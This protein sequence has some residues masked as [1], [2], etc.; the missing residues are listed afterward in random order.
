M[1]FCPNKA[2]KDWVYSVEKLG[3]ERTL[4]MY[5]ALGQNI[6]T[7]E[8]VDSIKLEVT[9]IV[10][11]KKGFL[12]SPQQVLSL[13][14][15]TKSV[16]EAES[17]L[18]GYKRVI[19]SKRW[20][21]KIWVKSNIDTGYQQDYV[22][23]AK[24]LEDKVN[25]IYPNLIVVDYKPAASWKHQRAIH[26]VWVNKIEWEKYFG[27]NKDKYFTQGVLFKGG[28]EKSIND[29]RAKEIEDVK[30]FLSTIRNETDAYEV[31]N[32][33]LD[34]Y[35]GI[36][37]S[38]LELIGWI[39]EVRHLNPNISF[40]IAE[41]LEDL[42]EK[43]PDQD[44]G[45]ES[46]A[47]YIQEN[48]TIVL[49]RPLITN[50]LYSDNNTVIASVIHE[51]LHSFTVAPFYKT[52][53]ELTEAEKEFVDNIT[54]LYNESKKRSKYKDE[55]AYTSVKEFIADGLAET[56]IIAELK[57]MK[58]P[59]DNLT[60]WEKI[61]HFILKLFGKSPFTESH[62]YKLLSTINDYVYR[63]DYRQPASGS[64]IVDAK[65][66]K[67][68]IFIQKDNPKHT[69]VID[70]LEATENAYDNLGIKFEGVT[71]IMSR[72][73]LGSAPYELLDDD[74]KKE[75]DKYSHIGS[76]THF[77]VEK[78]FSTYIDK[79]KTEYKL[80]PE[81]VRD[82]E[83]MFSRF[84]K[85]GV[86]ILSEV[87]VVDFVNKISGIIDLVVIDKENKVHLFDIKTKVSGFE[88]FGRA[89]WAKKGQPTFFPISA[90]DKASVQLTVYR[91]MFEEITK[92]PVETMQVIPLKP[93]VDENT[94]SILRV[95]LDRTYNGKDII[96]INANSSYTRLMYSV[97]TISMNPNDHQDM[98]STKEELEGI[99]EMSTRFE[100]L[101]KSKSA[102]DEERDILLKIVKSIENRIEI[103]AKSG[104]ANVESQVKHLNDILKK[105][106]DED[107]QAALKHAI[108]IA[109]KITKNSYEEIEKLESTGADITPAKLARLKE[110]V[111]T[112]DTIDELKGM[113]DSKY[114]LDRKVLNALDEDKRKELLSIKS[115]L[116]DTIKYKEVVKYKYESYGLNLMVDFLY[117]FYNKVRVQFRNKYKK[118]YRA[119]KEDG[120]LPNQDLTEKE[121]V[122]SKLTNEK[123]SI[124]SLSKTTIRKELKKAAKD[125]GKL[126]AWV[127]NIL[128]SP[129]AV[130]AALVKAFVIYDDTAR[131][132]IEKERLIMLPVV[133]EFQEF[134]KQY[135]KDYQKAYNFMLERKLGKN[136]LSGHLVSRLHSDLMK[137][138]YNI[139]G[140]ANTIEDETYR[141]LFI[142]TWK[143]ENVP[144]DKESF[145]KAKLDYLDSLL[146]LKKI[147][148]EE[149]D[150][151][152][153]NLVSKDGVSVDKLENVSEEAKDLII[154][155]FKRNTWKHRNPTSKWANP[156]WEE[157]QKILANPDDPRTKMYNLIIDIQEK[158]DD[159]VPTTVK[160]GTQLPGVI[161]QKNE[162][163]AAGQNLADIAKDSLS[164]TFTFKVDDTHRVKTEIV[165]LEG[166]AKY[167][168]PVH[169]S[170][171]VTKTI[172]DK[173][174][175]N[176]YQVFDP[177]NQSFDLANI[178]YRYLAAAID[179]NWKNEI[180][181]EMELHK[182]LLKNRDVVKRDAF[183]NI[184]YR[185]SRIFKGE[186]S[187]Y[188]EQTIKG[189]N[190]FEQY[191]TW[192][193]YALYGQAEK[194]LGTIPGTN[195]DAGKF[196]RFLTR[197]TSLNLLGLNVVA[198]VANVMLGHTMQM[199][200][201]FAGQHM[202]KESYWKAHSVYY[203]NL[204]GVM[205]DIGS[206]KPENIVN[207][208]LREFN[209]LHDPKTRNLT[210]DKFSDLMTLDAVF[211]TSHIGEFSMQTKWMLG[212]LE[213]KRAYDIDGKDVG[214]MLDNYEV[215]DGKLKL[216][217]IVSEEKSNW[218]FNERR[219]FEHALRGHLNRLHG[220]YSDL[221]RVAIQQ[222]AITGMAYMY[223]KFILPGA[224]RRW[225]A[226]RYEER[227][228]EVHEGNYRT[229]INF[230][231]QLMKN[232]RQY[233]AV[234][235]SKE[236]AKLD[237]EEK[238]NMYRAIGEVVSLI[239]AMIL[240]KVATKLASDDDKEG[241]LFWN[242]MSY[243][244]LRLKSELMFFI[245]PP[246]AMKILRSPAASISVVENIFKIL[247]DLTG[248]GFEEY[249]Q[250][251]WKGHLK[252][253]KKLIDMTIGVRQYFRLRDIG[254]QIPLWK[255]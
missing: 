40:Y 124:D 90:F 111:A 66:I 232:L 190:I 13:L 4:F 3:E 115:L 74:T 41:S 81:A 30:S 198:G 107:V 236:W 23:I 180:L 222:N 54:K 88:N 25:A 175:G 136:E 119:L 17:L 143:D 36:P 191:N 77:Q 43:Y 87:K 31:V 71:H 239:L 243:Q 78:N 208:L 1:T 57:A 65:K 95:E 113:F 29:L 120:K 132:E 149:F 219:I 55:Y 121:Y 159:L 187:E 196:V 152:Q 168:V 52:N 108:S 161:K 48:N 153:Y 169:F 86:T 203:K 228:E 24:D 215:K 99:Q 51:I 89:Y 82:I 248:P 207:L 216:K 223:R 34:F 92:L 61:K 137:E 171:R 7:K 141:K 214:S 205:G 145:G 229:M 244:V 26:E 33:I 188:D 18:L 209:V 128:D 114:F 76:E 195:I 158:A 64:H 47:Y 49:Y 42:A 212:E 250:G 194:D 151:L 206:R 253:E 197:F 204:P 72:L 12:T 178:Y 123:E 105:L 93:I 21:K 251:P 75:L 160:I 101:I 252:I 154:N 110:S 230:N 138:Y 73:R 211:F 112:F 37:D 100:A 179:F 140:V 118:E 6:P 200:E 39:Q 102:L 157:L 46:L 130:T 28:P 84:K 240:I 176:E 60:F 133:L 233:K 227:T 245:S 144:L 98:F 241:D 172:K 68:N 238:A 184:K 235:L 192:L 35:D 199:V 14:P 2:H 85:E 189:G 146:E 254:E 162:R 59:K 58:S 150:I 22:V 32:R 170:G 224:R 186:K 103:T 139:L 117:P 70:A 8:Q 242:F 9:P 45:G 163:I 255:M 134:T 234:M 213:E 218:T 67:D 97:Q 182:F 217:D 142:S 126:E 10:E 19:G 125:I 38:N 181:P 94:K 210:D 104:R 16:E 167:F 165:D 44:F 127:D 69:E 106:E 20:E 226:R 173:E 15:T 155:W 249:E 193:S 221:G 122:E 246:Q 185:A 62:D 80:T 53:D 11:S 177:D 225:G 79:L 27:E 237:D 135:G 220:E 91:N 129:D 63:A 147:S 116:E 50:P 174:T 96:P 202:S 83:S 231:V 56:H 166:N 131:I 164:K 148:K 156:Q 183:G 5:D 201:A 247:Q 109:H